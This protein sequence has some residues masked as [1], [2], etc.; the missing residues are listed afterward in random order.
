[1]KLSK[2]FTQPLFRCSTCNYFG[3]HFVY[4]T[5]PDAYCECC[6]H[7][8]WDQ[9]PLDLRFFCKVCD[10]ELEHVSRIDYEEAKRLGTSAE[11][12]YDD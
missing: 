12:G 9:H 5:N 4:H 10:T 6:G 3:H 11:W 7:L 8:K 2:E 1:M